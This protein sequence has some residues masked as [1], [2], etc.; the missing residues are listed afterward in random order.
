[1][2]RTKRLNK[3]ASKKRAYLFLTIFCTLLVSLSVFVSLD[4]M[5]KNNEMQ[6]QLS[7][8]QRRIEAEE[9]RGTELKKLAEYLKTDEFAEQIAREVLGLVKENEILFKKK[10]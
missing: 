3:R 1:M 8:A 10:Q 6:R 2:K 7:A 5:K 9:E 4:Q